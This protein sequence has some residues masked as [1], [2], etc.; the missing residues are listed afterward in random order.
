MV[1]NEENYDM[2]NISK[3]NLDKSNQ[4]MNIWQFMKTEECWA[5]GKGCKKYCWDGP[6]EA[7]RGINEGSK[8]KFR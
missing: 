8:C 6:N 4:K 5:P 2:G 7:I 3:G 1:K